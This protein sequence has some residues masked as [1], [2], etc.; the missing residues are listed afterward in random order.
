MSCKV[1]KKQKANQSARIK[2]KKKRRK[3]SE[4]MENQRGGLNQKMSVKISTVKKSKM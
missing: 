3:G 1:N 2:A 4:H